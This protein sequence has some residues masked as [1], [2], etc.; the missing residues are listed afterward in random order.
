MA[1]FRRHNRWIQAWNAVLDAFASLTGTRGDLIYYGASN[2]TTLPVGTA[3]QVLH[4]DGTDPAWSTVTINAADEIGGASA[5]IL[6]N[7]G[8]V[9]WGSNGS[10]TLVTGSEA[11]DIQVSGETFVDIVAQAGDINLKDL[12]GTNNVNIKDVNTTWAQFDNTNNWL[13]VGQEPGAGALQAGTTAGTSIASWIKAAAPA[14]TDWW[15]RF[16]MNT[17]ADS[18]G[19]FRGTGINTKDMLWQVD[20][21]AYID[22]END[23]YLDA[24]TLSD[25]LIQRAATTYAQFDGGLYRLIMTNPATAGTPE[26]LRLDYSAQANP[27]TSF[28]WATWHDLG[29]E[30]GALTGDGSGGWVVSSTG[31]VTVDSV[32]DVFIQQ[33]G[34]TWLSLDAGL[35]RIIWNESTANSTYID[36][37]TDLYLAADQDIYLDPD[38]NRDVFIAEGGTVWA[39][40]DGSTRTLAVEN[41]ATSGSGECIRADYS[42]WATVGTSAYYFACYDSGGV[43]G[44]LTGD[45]ANGLQLL[46]ND[47]ITFTAGG[48]GDMV[49]GA[50]GELTITPGAN[51]GVTIEKQEAQTTISH[52]LLKVSNTYTGST[53]RAMY[54]L[55]GTTSAGTDN[56]YL[57]F[58]DSNTGLPAIGKVTGNGSGGAVYNTTSDL[59]KKRNVR[60]AQSTQGALAKVSA[61]RNR[62]WQHVA[63]PAPDAPVWCGWVAQELYEVWPQA[64]QPPDPSLPP[65]HPDAIWSVAPM[66]LIPLLVAAIQEMESEISRLR[67]AV[68][69]P[70]PA[71]ESPGGT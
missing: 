59:R 9:Y 65:D 1:R 6:D 40:F 56:W 69:A 34:T 43:V 58:R 20:A 25:V 4:N 53:T 33:A 51:T 19:G 44:G 26:L 71:P 30:V 17:A 31:D 48:S 2:W 15:L 41:P 61:I 57:A 46:C 14:N 23:I 67:A 21:D 32:D 10:G 68:E 55:M 29:G 52:N 16:Y 12:F 18:A 70:G 37:Y 3:W 7:A 36:G 47:D 35:R 22:A 42:S 24:G 50:D 63:N 66:E 27:S 28:H 49:L 60:D 8:S 54:I 62:E 64:V 11:G 38:D 39:T 5:L 13:W 45:G